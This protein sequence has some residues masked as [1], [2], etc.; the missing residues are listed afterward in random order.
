MVEAGGTALSTAWTLNLLGVILAVVGI[1]FLG[2]L[3][4]ISSAEFGTDADLTLLILPIAG[5]ASGT[6]LAAYYAGR[7]RPVLDLGMGRPSRSERLVL[8]VGLVASGAAAFLALY[9]GGALLIVSGI[10]YWFG[11]RP[12]RVAR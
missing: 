6:V 1:L 5:A 4:E 10:L 8:T 3:V 12:A 11:L 7:L 9:I 2:F